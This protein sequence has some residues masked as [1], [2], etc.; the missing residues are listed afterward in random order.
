MALTKKKGL[1]EIFTINHIYYDKQCIKKPSMRTLKKLRSSTH[2]SGF[3]SMVAE[4]GFSE[5]VR[6]VSEHVDNSFRSCGEQFQIMSEQFQIMSRIVSERS[7]HPKC[8][9]E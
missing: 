7:S 8:H 4:Y 9:S 6:T 1:A 5:H 2:F 3:P